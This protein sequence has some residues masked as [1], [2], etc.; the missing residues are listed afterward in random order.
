MSAAFGRD[1]EPWIDADLGRTRAGRG[2]A[3]AATANP[4]ASWAAMRILNSGGSAID[5]AIAAQAVLTAVEPN[6]SGL[7]GG[8]LILVAKGGEAQNYDG[9]GAA[10]AH[11][12]DRLSRDVDGRSIPAER[13]DFGGRTVGVPGCL[14]ALE[15]AHATHGKLPWAFL[16]AP[17]IRLARDGFVLCKRV[18]GRVVRGDCLFHLGTDLFW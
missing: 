8:C 3:A 5:A 9:L 12:T 16:F 17:A 13:C 10:P 14:R 6:A 15:L 18:P 2:R 4:L 7:G 1:L 11:V